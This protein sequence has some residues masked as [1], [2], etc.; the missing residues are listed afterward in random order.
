[1]LSLEA[2]GPVTFSPAENPEF[3]EGFPAHASDKR[4]QPPGMDSRQK[5]LTTNFGEVGKTHR[6]AG[7]STTIFFGRSNLLLF[8]NMCYLG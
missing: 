7:K 5:I 8:G 2:C 4:L 6:G 1:M 3:F